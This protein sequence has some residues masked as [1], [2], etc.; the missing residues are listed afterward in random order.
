MLDIN[1]VSLFDTPNIRP[2][3][4]T[5][6]NEKQCK[7]SNLDSGSYDSIEYIPADKGDYIVGVYGSEG[8]SIDYKFQWSVD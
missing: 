7:S 8:Y 6:V 4:D 3:T 5:C 2:T 1:I